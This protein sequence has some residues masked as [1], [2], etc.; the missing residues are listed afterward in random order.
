M[1]F[2]IWTVYQYPE[3]YPGKFVARCFDL[4]KPTVAVIVA[5]GLEDLRSLLPKGLVRLERNEL[6]DP[7]ILETWL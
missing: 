6:D 2:P 3:D 7:V 5:D 1:K 4:D